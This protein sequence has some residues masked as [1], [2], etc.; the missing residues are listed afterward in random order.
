ME[1][2]EKLQDIPLNIFSIDY[3]FLPPQREVEF[4]IECVSGTKP[5]SKALYKMALVELKEQK[6]LRQVLLD[7]KLIFA[8]ALHHGES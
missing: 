6:E 1:E 4:G 5:T 8:Q 7:K 3:A 2:E